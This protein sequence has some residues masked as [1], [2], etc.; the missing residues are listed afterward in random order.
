M[1]FLWSTIIAAVVILLLILLK[2]T[3]IRVNAQRVREHKQP[4]PTTSNPVEVIDW[5]R[6]R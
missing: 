3:E 6:R 4:Y 2:A 5:S 1:M